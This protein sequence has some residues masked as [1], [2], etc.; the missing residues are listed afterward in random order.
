MQAQTNQILMW[1]IQIESW[2]QSTS[3]VLTNSDVMHL[4]EFGSCYLQ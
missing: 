1:Q 3:H 2:N 4:R